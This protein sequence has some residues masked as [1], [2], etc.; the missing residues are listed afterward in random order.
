MTCR[1]DPCYPHHIWTSIWKPN[2][3]KKT[4]DFSGVFFVFAPI[5]DLW[6]CGWG[7]DL[8]DFGASVGWPYFLHPFWPER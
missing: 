2:G 7:G 5:L 6:G 3:V 8:R 4:S 1:F